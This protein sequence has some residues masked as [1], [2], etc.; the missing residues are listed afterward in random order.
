MTWTGATAFVL[1][2]F[3]AYTMNLAAITAGIVLSPEAHHDPRKRYTAA[4]SAGFFYLVVGAFGA[5]VAALLA[6]F[7]KEMVLALAGLA[8]LPTIGSGLATAVRDDRQREAAIVTFLV[9]ASG[10][11]LANIGSA[12]WGLIAG[13]ATMLI[14][15]AGRRRTVGR[16]GAEPAN[17]DR[18]AEEEPVPVAQERTIDL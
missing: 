1:A 16:M 9:T 7:P 3:G 2:P 8:L 4:V 11:T 12:F 10:L 13:V 15:H 5:S 6:L 18:P 17:D 14:L